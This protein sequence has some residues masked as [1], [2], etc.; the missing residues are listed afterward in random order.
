MKRNNI[1]KILSVLL[2]FLLIVNIVFNNECVISATETLTSEEQK[3]V[4]EQKLKQTEVRL[5][6]LSKNS[7][8]TQEYLDTLENKL[9]YLR[10][11]YSITQKECE[12]LQSDV[13]NTEKEIENN[14]NN[15]IEAKQMLVS[16]E[17]QMQGLNQDFDSIYQRYCQRLRAMYVSQSQNTYLL[18]LLESKGI[19]NFLIRLQMFS[20]VTE[21]DSELLNTVNAQMDGIIAKRNEIEE[22]QKALEQRSIDL[23]NNE[24][25]LKN[26]RAVLFSRDDELKQQKAKIEEEQASANS[27]LKILNDESQKY[28]E[29]RD[30]TKEELMQIDS[31]IA[32]G[33]EKYQDVEPS[34]TPNDSANDEN[35]TNPNDENQYLS[36]TFPCPSYTEITCGFGEYEGHSG[37]DFSTRSNENEKIV[38]AESGTVILVKLLEKS[39]GHY[40]VIRHDKTTKK[41]EI[42][43]TLYAHNNDIIVNEG[44]Y[45][46]KGQQIAYSGTTGNSTGPHCHFE[47]RVGGSSQSYA[48]DP[49]NYLPIGSG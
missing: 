3:I 49:K 24:L 38:A 28:G 41:G 34:T 45:V 35:T 46:Y 39:Y 10:Q 33:D 44:D 14:K 25:K 27:L 20:S 7:T 11:Q 12:K 6:Y 31:E 15:I 43:Y 40:V 22:K 32:F 36:L 16:L 18:F 19:E 2:A 5:K 48:R 4:L 23:E 26:Q 9:E 29:Y 21:A 13:K 17:S 37:C 42:V 8:K 30:I 1:L 47:V